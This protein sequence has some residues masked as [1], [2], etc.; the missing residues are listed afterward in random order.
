MYIFDLR[1]AKVSKLARA[2]SGEIGLT[3]RSRGNSNERS[4]GEQFE[5]ENFMGVKSTVQDGQIELDQVP[6]LAEGRF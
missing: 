1:I 5:S 2:Q 3:C 4:D 6:L